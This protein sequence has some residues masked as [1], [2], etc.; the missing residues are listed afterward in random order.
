MSNSEFAS[1]I[2]EMLNHYGSCTG[3]QD[4]MNK[5]AELVCQ[6]RTLQ[7]NFMRLIVA[8]IDTKAKESYCDGRDEATDRLCKKLSAVMTDE[9]RCLPFI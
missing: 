4:C 7:Q 3:R 2:M 6:H 5:A 9:D 8:F 1:K